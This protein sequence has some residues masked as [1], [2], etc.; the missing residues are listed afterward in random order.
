M[1]H[2]ILG[3]MYA[4]K[5]TK[6]LELYELYRGVVFD[7]AE[8]NGEGFMVSHNKKTVPCLKR[9][10]LIDSEWITDGPL[11]VNEAQFFP[12]LLAFVKKWESVY[13]IYLFGLDGDFQRKPFEPIVQVLPLCDTMIKLQGTCA[14]CPAPSLFSKR[15]TDHQETYLL[16]ESAY[17]PICRLCYLNYSGVNQQIK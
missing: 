13:D 11:F 4:G 2:L 5:T 9:M 7:Y 14:L 3:P 10:T 17:I 8:F 1:I 16:D 15:I 12:D 6:L